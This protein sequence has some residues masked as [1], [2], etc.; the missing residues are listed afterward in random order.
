MAQ[1]PICQRGK[2]DAFA[3]EGRNDKHIY[4]PSTLPGLLVVRPEAGLVE[5]PASEFQ[6]VGC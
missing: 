5:T 3:R 1:I 6:R 2:E 4:R